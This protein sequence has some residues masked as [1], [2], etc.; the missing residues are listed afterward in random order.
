[1]GALRLRVLGTPLRASISV[2]IVAFAAGAGVGIVLGRRKKS[3]V[4]HHIPDDLGLDI[5]SEDLDK[6]RARNAAKRKK[7]TVVIPSLNELLPH[8]GRRRNT[9]V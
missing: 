5:S 2:G 4:L 3:T 8:F 9:T 7:G 6:V 1:M